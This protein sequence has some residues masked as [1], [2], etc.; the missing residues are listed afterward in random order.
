LVLADVAGL[1]IRITDA[2]RPTACDGVRFRNQ[3]GF[4]SKRIDFGRFLFYQSLVH[5]H[6]PLPEANVMIATFGDLRQFSPIY[7]N[8]IRKN[9]RFSHKNQFTDIFSA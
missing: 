9:W 5:S 3:P 8:F 4:A 2:L 1:A 6:S 7:A